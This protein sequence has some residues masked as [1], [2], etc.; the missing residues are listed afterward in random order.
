MIILG[1]KEAEGNTI[2]VRKQGH[3]DIGEMEIEAFANLINSEIK[4]YFN[5]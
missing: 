5:N 3:G 2:S 1:E 4:E